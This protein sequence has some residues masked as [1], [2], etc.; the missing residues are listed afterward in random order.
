MRI[1]RSSWLKL[2]Q[3]LAHQVERRV[4]ESFAD[5]LNEQETGETTR[6]TCDRETKAHLHRYARE[7]SVDGVQ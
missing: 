7:A 1:R 6:P 2:Y 3:E 5:T 4:L